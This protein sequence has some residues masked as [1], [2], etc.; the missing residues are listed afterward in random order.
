MHFNES[1]EECARRE[2]SEETG[3]EID[4]VHIRA[5]I[6]DVNYNDNTHYINFFVTAKLTGGQLKNGEPEDISTWKWYAVD[7]IPN[8]LFYNIKHLFSV[9]SPNELL[10]SEQLVICDA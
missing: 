9:I 1:I 6:N 8:P 2:I 5:V 4:Q 7:N 3:L 10:S